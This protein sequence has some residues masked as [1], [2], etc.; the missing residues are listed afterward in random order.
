M[1]FG[2]QGTPSRKA[3]VQETFRS[4][5]SIDETYERAYQRLMDRLDTEAKQKEQNDKAR[6][7]QLQQF[8]EQERH[9]RLQQKQLQLAH[10]EMLRRQ[11]QDNHKKRLMQRS[12][13]LSP[14]F[15]LATF[16]LIV[17]EE[18]FT[19]L[20]KQQIMSQGLEQQLRDKE[21]KTA[22]RRHLDAEFEANQASVWKSQI[23]ANRIK[24]MQERLRV[25]DDLTKS[26]SDNQRAKSFMRY[27]E[28]EAK[29]KP[30]IGSQSPLETTPRKNALAYRRPTN[31][32]AYID[33]GNLSPTSPMS[34]NSLAQSPVG[35]R[36]LS[37]RELAHQHKEQLRLNE[38][39]DLKIQITANASRLSSHSPTASYHKKLLDEAADLIVRVTQSRVQNEGV[40]KHR[41]PKPSRNRLDPATVKQLL[42]TLKPKGAMRSLSQYGRNVVAD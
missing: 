30:L 32:L 42:G 34:S 39:N 14:A 11:A 17:N 35:D 24:E 38:I 21:K 22:E 12:F 23:E 3:S 26:W 9:E 13:D 7:L 25:R 4:G 36:H 27:I 10:A 2:S 19:K 15:D 8:G 20:Q 1:L 6:Q 5:S 37:R 29:S 31:E 41:Q 33:Q 28:G 16:P 18:R 40:I